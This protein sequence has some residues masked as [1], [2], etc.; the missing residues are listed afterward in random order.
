MTW[1]SRLF[2]RH[3]RNL[4]LVAIL[5]LSAVLIYGNNDLN[6]YVNRTT[7]FFSWPFSQVRCSIEE[8]SGVNAENQRLQ[9][10]LVEA[11]LRLTELDEI[12]RENRRLRSI[13]EFEPEPG[14]SLLPARVVKVVGDKIPVS[15]VVINRGQEDS[16]LVNQTVINQEGLVGRI[17][18]VW[19]G[20]AEVQLLT[21]MANR[22][23]VRVAESQEM[24]VVKYIAS[25]GM[26]LENFPIQGNIRQGD[27]ILS[28]GLGGVYPARLVVGTV[29][30]V[31][32]PEEEAFC[33]VLLTPAVSFS[34]LQEVF[35]L[36]PD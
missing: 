7:L 12:R 36:R 5:L 3:S 15:A 2:S 4:H 13:L 28:S 16:V 25:R 6:R 14:Y 1:I 35:I 8:L 10:S 11:S 24:G 33:K 30:S 34:S 21:H 23:A 26:I 22:V 20:G 18:E 29:A 27:L 19:P 32:K 31:E 9:Q 17:S